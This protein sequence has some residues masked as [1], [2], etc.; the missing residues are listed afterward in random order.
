MGKNKLDDV[1]AKY[2]GVFKLKNKFIL[3][4][5]CGPKMMWYNKNHPNVLYV[6]KRRLKP[7]FSKRRP[8]CKI[9]PDVLADFTNFKFKDKSFKLVVWD[10]PHLKSKKLTCDMTKK[11]GA[12]HPE[13]WQRDL[14]L[15]FKEIWRVLEDY[16]V[17][18]FKWGDR[19]FKTKEVLR[20]FKVKP[21]FGTKTNQRENSITR[22]FCFMKIPKGEK[23]T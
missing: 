11:Y 20:L 3:D 18:I 19:D 9:D 17:L 23:K 7:G 4:A 10:P 1:R 8:N 14:K 15:G 13:T 5:C 22:W 16:G 2:E 21:L 12:L 6:D